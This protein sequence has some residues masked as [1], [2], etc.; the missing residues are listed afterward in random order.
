[1]T[2]QQIE[3]YFNEIGIDF[4]KLSES[5]KES[6]TNTTKFKMYECGVAFREFGM[7][8]KECADRIKQG[9]SKVKV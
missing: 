9:F 6:L 4:N 7:S 2:H 8:L 3:S 1:M 5:E